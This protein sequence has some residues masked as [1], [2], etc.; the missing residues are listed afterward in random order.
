MIVGETLLMDCWPP[1]RLNVR[2]KDEVRVV[3]LLVLE[4]QSSQGEVRSGVSFLSGKDKSPATEAHFDPLVQP[5]SA[6]RVPKPADEQ[7]LS[8][9]VRPRLDGLE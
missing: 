9:S 6:D 5:A 1:G 3:G 4:L 2:T 8:A 7:K